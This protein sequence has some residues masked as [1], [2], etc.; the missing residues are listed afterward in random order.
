MNFEVKRN[1]QFTKLIKAEGRLREFNFTR[2]TGLMDGIF[3]LDVVDDRGNRI[4]LQMKQNPDGWQI[5]EIELPEWITAN[6]P[7]LQ[8]FIEEELNEDYRIEQMRQKAAQSIE[9]KRQIQRS[10]VEE[11]LHASPQT[12]KLL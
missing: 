7:Q 4:I 11:I 1:L 8:Q 6:K 9:K 10:F 5:R 3:S 2:L 12:L